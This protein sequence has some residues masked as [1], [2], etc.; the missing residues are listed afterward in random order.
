M[1]RAA[2]TITYTLLLLLLTIIVFNDSHAAGIRWTDRY[3]FYKPDNV[4]VGEYISK[5]DRTGNYGGQAKL[6]GTV[7]ATIDGNPFSFNSFKNL[8]I[9]DIAALG[10]SLVKR[11]GPAMV[12][13]SLAPLIW[14]EVAKLWQK[15]QSPDVQNGF[16]IDHNNATAVCHDIA[17]DTV[18]FAANGSACTKKCICQQM[19]EPPWNSAGWAVWDTANFEYCHTNK[20]CAYGYWP[21]IWFRYSGYVSAPFYVPV[22][23]GEILSA[24]QNDLSDV[25]NLVAFIAKLIEKGL[26]QDVFNTSIFDHLE[27]PSSFTTTSSSTSTG[28]SGQTSVNTQNTY[29]ISYNTNTVTITKTTTTTTTNP[30]NSTETHTVVNNPSTGVTNPLE[31]PETPETDVCKLHPE[32]LACATQGTIDDADLPEDDKTFSMTSE[33]SSAGQCPPDIQLSYM[34]KSFVVKW[35]LVCNFATMLRPLVLILATLSAGLFTF[36]VISRA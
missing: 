32:I 6:K 15:N 20:G 9:G 34:G 14:D 3:P 31:T 24:L 11:V 27:G 21:R 8:P 26:A 2:L 10:L 36:F 5:F 13:G 19:D 16:S 33:M 18:K 23:D 7:E 28:P 4:L 22:T 35:T 17:I 29:N 1:D 12:V 25:S 30:D